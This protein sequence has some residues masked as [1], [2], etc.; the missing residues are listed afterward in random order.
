[1]AKQKEQ[2]NNTVGKPLWGGVLIVIGV[3]F[4]LSNFDIIP[5]DTFGKLWPL[6]IIVP[7]VIM[8]LQAS[9]K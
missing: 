5:S 8:I 2:D 9:K 3:I 6:F 7:G 4:L 1:M